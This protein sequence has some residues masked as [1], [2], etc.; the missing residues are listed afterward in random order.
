MS[1]PMSILFYKNCQPDRKSPRIEI[2]PNRS[3]G[4]PVDVNLNVSLSENLNVNLLHVK[5]ELQQKS[6]I[7]RTEK[8]KSK[9]QVDRAPA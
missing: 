3:F 7:L 5:G 9:S 8:L 4:A 1:K 2:P 6:K